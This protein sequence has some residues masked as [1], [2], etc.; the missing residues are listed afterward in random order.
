MIKK[1]IFKA[2]DIRGLYPQDLNEEVAYK[3]AQAYCKLF[4]PKTIVLGRDVRLSGPSL[5]RAAAK[6][7]TDHGVD[8]IDIGVITTDMLYY[9]SAALNADGGIT[10]SASHNPGEYNGMKLMRAGAVP[11]SGDTGILEIRDLVVSDYAFKAPLAG[12]I[13]V[14]DIRAD[15]LKKCLSF[16]DADSIEEPRRDGRGKMRVVVNGMFGAVVKNVEQ[17][18]DIA[19]LPIEL[20][21]LNAEPDGSFPKGAPDPL[22]PENRTETI[23]LIKSVKADLGAAWDGDADRVF[24]FDETGRFIPGYFITAFLGAYFSKKA[25]GSKIIY[26]PRLTWAVED[27]VK[28][29]GG[30]ALINRVG[31]SFIKERMRKE[32][33]VFGGE[34]SGHY[35]FREFYYADNGLIPF[36]LMLEIISKSGKKV[37]ELFEPYFKKYFISDETNFALES[38]GEV[39]RAI[40]KIE[41]AYPDA[42]VTRVDGLSIEYSKWRANIRSS[43]TQPLLRIN[44]EAKNEALRDQKL[45]ELIKLIQGV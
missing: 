33:A 6:G 25:P 37:S 2:Y 22:L 44:V 23:A 21:T 20:I 28:S 40:S 39:E 45:A 36:L 24:F 27:T 18:K 4:S 42:T 10:I 9:A 32:N 30:I 14:Q 5:W 35:Y 26:D 29:A 13:T 31:H 8:V 7:F 15:Y 38:L 16:V 11:V 1:E 41:Y 17:A 3:I 12:V 34:L 43:N 19:K